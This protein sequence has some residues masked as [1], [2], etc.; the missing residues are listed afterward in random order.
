MGACIE[1]LKPKFDKIFANHA[2]T[3]LSLPRQPIT[4]EENIKALGSLRRLTGMDRDDFF[5][6]L[7]R[8]PLAIREETI[9]KWISHYQNKSSVEVLADA[10]I[11]QLLSDVNKSV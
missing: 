5:F 10:N 7:L 4:Y 6:G 11:Q 1:I 2:I 9:V 3:T 8:T